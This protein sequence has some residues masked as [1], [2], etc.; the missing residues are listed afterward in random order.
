V[1]IGMFAA[2]VVARRVPAE[3]PAREAGG[4]DGPGIALLAV[5]LLAFLLA[6]DQAPL[7]G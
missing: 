5:A 3:R 4:L 2:L 1:P 7:W 6:L